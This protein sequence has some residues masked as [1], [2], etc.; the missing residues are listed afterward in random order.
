MFI[1]DPY[2]FSGGTNA[3]V[4]KINNKN[5]LIILKNGQT[6]IKKYCNENNH[7]LV[8][9]RDDFHANEPYIVDVYFRDPVRRY[10]SAL[11]TVKE[12]NREIYDHVPMPH[13]RDYFSIEKAMFV[14]PHTYPQYWWLIHAYVMSFSSDNLYFKFNDF[15][16]I[17][18][19]VGDTHE[20][21]TRFK[22][23]FG[24][25]VKTNK[26]VY[27]SLNKTE[28]DAVDRRYYFDIKIYE[29]LIGKTLNYNELMSCFAEWIDIEPQSSRKG[30]PRWAEFIKKHHPKNFKE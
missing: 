12:L 30:W 19:L 25:R 17:G 4:A 26:P 10:L 29:N 3:E 15:T 2:F 27:Q 18:E 22:N 14:D 1:H 28:M 21:Q 6:S 11:T 9:L 23:Q 7:K 24:R 20:N 16:K 13:T 5:V 8:A